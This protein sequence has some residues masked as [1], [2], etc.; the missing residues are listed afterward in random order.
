MPEPKID[1]EQAKKTIEPLKI[2]PVKDA[3]GLLYNRKYPLRRLKLTIEGEKIE[4]VG[5]KE[6]KPNQQWELQEQGEGTDNFLLV[7]MGHREHKL[8]ATADKKVF[9]DGGVFSPS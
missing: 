9:A 1:I 6:S 4:V 2:E 5:D 8:S 3:V 7:N